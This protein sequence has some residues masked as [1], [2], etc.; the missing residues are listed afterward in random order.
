M[1]VHLP[2]RIV[3]STIDGQVRSELMHAYFLN[4]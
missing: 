3:F 1:I 4:Q 2:F